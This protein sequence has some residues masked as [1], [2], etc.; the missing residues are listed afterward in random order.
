M[1][2]L[3][4]LQ[5]FLTESGIICADQTDVSRCLYHSLA[6]GIKP[7]LAIVE[8]SLAH[9]LPHWEVSP[10]FV[11]KRDRDSGVPAQVILSFFQIFLKK[12]A[13]VKY[14][15]DTA[16]LGKYFEALPFS[17]FLKPFVSGSKL[18]CPSKVSWEVSFSLYY[19]V[20]CG[21]CLGNVV[22]GMEKFG[23]MW[24]NVLE[25]RFYYTTIIHSCIK[26]LIFSSNF[27]FSLFSEQ[28]MLSPT[29]IKYIR[30]IK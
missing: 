22:I 21:N 16:A 18:K 13:F 14:F 6:L 27:Y 19:S 9:Q 10:L 1:A 29:L 26:N 23:K 30:K 11:R 8:D 25:T 2:I 3:T 17:N 12:T 15:E 5:V 20:I 4:L 24:K 7:R 28:T